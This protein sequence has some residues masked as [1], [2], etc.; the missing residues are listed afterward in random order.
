MVHICLISALYYLSKKLEFTQQRDE[1]GYQKKAFE[2]GFVLSCAGA[3]LLKH[4]M[5]AAQSDSNIVE[6]YL[7]VQTS[8][9]GAVKFYQRFGFRTGEVIPNYYRRLSPP[10][11]LM[12]YSPLST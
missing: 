3:A 7:H 1:F 6:A 9:D 8:N 10:D 11:A 12:L 4:T 2:K 5:M